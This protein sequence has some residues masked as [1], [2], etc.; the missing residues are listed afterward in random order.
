MDKKHLVIVSIVVA[1]V[2][3]IVLV[4][5]NLNNSGKNISTGPVT[6][7]TPSQRNDIPESELKSV[8]ITAD[9]GR[10]EPNFIR[11]AQ[12]DSINLEITA[13]EQDYI[14]QNNNFGVDQSIP[15][16]RTTTV[17]LDATQPSG[18]YQFLCQA[19]CIFKV[20]IFKPAD[21]DEE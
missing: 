19:N 17:R 1:A 14:L 15:E 21:S 3:L 9:S 5:N 4:A 18:M 11:L 2:L 13:L 12:L 10:F 7:L 6:A 20:E 8:L 16:G